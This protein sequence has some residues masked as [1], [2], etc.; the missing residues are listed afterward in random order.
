MQRVDADTTRPIGFT[1]GV[2]LVWSGVGGGEEAIVELEPGLPRYIEVFRQRGSQGRP[3]SVR[4]SSPLEYLHLIQESGVY[5]YTVQVSG[6][7]M[8]LQR[9]SIDIEWDEE[10]KKIT[11][12]EFA[13]ETQNNTVSEFPPPP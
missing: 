7:A 1:D 4:G 11:V 12:G 8:S 3:L 6:Q 13:T 2:R 5:R 9:A 10:Q